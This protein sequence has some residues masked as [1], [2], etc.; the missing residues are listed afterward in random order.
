MGTSP[1]SSMKF[2]S[3]F[4]RSSSLTPS[5]PEV[6]L[7][8]APEEHH[9]Q[10]GFIEE[11]LS[12]R[13]QDLTLPCGPDRCDGDAQMRESE[14]APSWGLPKT[15]RCGWASLPSAKRRPS[16]KA[17]DTSGVLFSSAHPRGFSHCDAASVK[18]MN[19]CSAPTCRSRQRVAQPSSKRGPATA[20]EETLPPSAPPE[21]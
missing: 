10:R 15:R 12:A 14:S 16:P 4:A 21:S 7:R 11:S 8:E 5:A 18:P 17:Q 20:G 1:A 9:E 6:P 19:S 2:G 3:A 13:R